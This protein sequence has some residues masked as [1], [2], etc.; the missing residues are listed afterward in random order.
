MKDLQ[1]V[2]FNTE[3]L[4]SHEGLVTKLVLRCNNRRCTSE[5]SSHSTHKKKL[6]KSYQINT[7]SRLGMRALGKGSNAVLKLLAIL[8]LGKSVTDVDLRKNNKII[9]EIYKLLME[10]WK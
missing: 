7:L 9:V 6:R 8:N 10:L 4:N 3:K 1:W 5:T 2:S